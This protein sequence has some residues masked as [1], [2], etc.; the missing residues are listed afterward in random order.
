MEIQIEEDSFSE[1]RA[2]TAREIQI[3]KDQYDWLKAILGYDPVVVMTN[4]V[5]EDVVDEFFSH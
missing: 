1:P 5:E 2:L 4:F 3:L